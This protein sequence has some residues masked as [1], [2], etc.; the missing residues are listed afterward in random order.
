MHSAYTP[1][2]YLNEISLVKKPE[3]NVSLMSTFFLINSLHIFIPQLH[4]SR[5]A[6]HKE[7]H[8]GPSS[9]ETETGVSCDSPPPPPLPPE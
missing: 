4:L 9:L 6:F 5:N 3:L 8:R 1:S 2:F 7:T